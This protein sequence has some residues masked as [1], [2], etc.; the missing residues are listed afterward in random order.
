MKLM[1]KVTII[2]LSVIGLLFFF[3]QDKTPDTQSSNANMFEIVAPLPN[4][5]KESSGIIALSKSGHFLTHNDAGNQPHLYEI[6]SDGKLVNTYKLNLPNVDWEDL[7]KDDKGNLYIA[8]TGNNDN[9]RK[10]LAIY[11]TSLNNPSKAEA[12]RFTYADQEQYPPAKKDM[13][14]DCEAIFWHDGNIYLISR[15]RGQKQT[16]KIYLLPD[17]PGKYEA[18][19]IGSHKINTQVTGADISPGAD[20]V[21]L[22]SEEKLHL[23]SNVTNPAEFYKGKY[24]EVPL[25]GSGQTEAVTFVN[26]NTLIITSEGGNIYRYKLE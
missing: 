8:D 1:L 14:F 9:K 17:K 3:L 12:I 10:E 11:K 23:F 19:L 15:D 21:A 2:F 24:K 6:T 7:A 13:N 5:V 22:I 18:K 20:M 4:Q 25:P 16:S 26:K